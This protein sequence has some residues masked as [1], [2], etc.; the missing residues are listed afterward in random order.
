M[1]GSE[2][3]LS[4]LGNVEF[5]YFITGVAMQYF[6]SSIVLFKFFLTEGPPIFSHVSIL[7]HPFLHLA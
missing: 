1:M 4:L 3:F 2:C 6:R 5:P 7:M